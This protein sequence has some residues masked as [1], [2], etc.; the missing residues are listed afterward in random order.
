[1]HTYILIFMFPHFRLPN[2]IPTTL[3]KSQNNKIRIS[4]SH[5][6]APTQPSLYIIFKISIYLSPQPYIKQCLENKR[7]SER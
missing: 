2:Y 3:L 1:M 4:L 7:D 5:L 6:T